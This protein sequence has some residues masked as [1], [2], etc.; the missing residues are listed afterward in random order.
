M[1]KQ[2]WR[3]LVR[4]FQRLFGTG[5]RRN[6]TPASVRAEPP[7]PL[8]D[9]DYEFLYSQLLEGVAHGWQQDRVLRFFDSLGDRGQS[10]LW[11]GWLRRFGERLL[12]S[13]APNN[14]LAARMVQLGQ[15]GCGEIGEVSYD[16]G[17]QLLTRNAPARA[18][19][20]PSVSSV[21]EYEEYDAPEEEV[22]AV[23]EE[24]EEGGELKTVTL[25]ELLVMLQQDNGLLQ[26]ISEQL[27]IETTDPQVIVQALL[28]QFNAANP[29][30]AEEAETP[31]SSADEAEAWFNQG[32]Q[33]AN[34]GELSDAIA[35]YD[36]CL[37]I[38]PDNYIAWNNRGVMQKNL[39]QLPEA[40]ASFGKAIEIKP[41][42]YEAWNN[43]GNTFQDLDRLE[44]AIASFDKAVEIK[45]NDPEA[46]YNRGLALENLNR[47][48]EALDSFDRV[49]QLQPNYPEVWMV[50]GETLH[51]LARYEEAIASYDQALQLK[52]DDWDSW[53]G[54]GKSALHSAKFD[55]L[56][57]SVSQIAQNNPALNQR[58]DEGQ[59]AS[60]E[61]GLK[62]V[63][64]ETD[65]E[66]WGRLH[67]AIGNAYYERSQVNPEP[68]PLRR[69]AL[70]EYQQVL[71]SLSQEDFP[72]LHHEILQDLLQLQQSLGQPSE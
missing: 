46:F 2:L 48:E 11:V 67:Q 69:Q 38:S 56:L 15:V 50:R 71:S 26:Q 7:K 51:R 33:Q 18:V 17:M 16:I 8:T 65:P 63:S 31:S 35:S 37:D 66:G 72:E 24:G 41:D 44:E 61:E 3:S 20:P 53:I 40:I 68:D 25:D 22:P 4:W 47:Y 6:P 59:L 62:Y 19:N 34:S 36:R 55:P 42:F 10:S 43:Q 30:S 29:P 52:L 9:T 14:E 13:P 12:A 58:G 49:L 64:Q 27:Q 5:G 23:S 70:I 28:N 54:R 32:N 45:R 60:Y 1:L 39:G 57:S 21:F